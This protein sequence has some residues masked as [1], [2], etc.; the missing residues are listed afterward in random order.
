MTCE[1]SDEIWALRS[2]LNALAL[3][4]VELAKFHEQSALTVLRLTEEVDR[5][6]GRIEEIEAELA[7]EKRRVA[8]LRGRIGSVENG[9]AS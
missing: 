8:L 2:D 4:M 5:E 1:H 9:W 6:R 7:V 3:Q